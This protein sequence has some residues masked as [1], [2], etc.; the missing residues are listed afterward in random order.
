MDTVSARSWITL[1]VTK[2]L[3]ADSGQ[4][5]GALKKSAITKDFRPVVLNAKANIEIK[6][7]VRSF[8]SHNVIGKLEGSDPKLN[9]EYVIY[10]AHWDHLGRHPELQGDQISTVQSITHRVW[11]Q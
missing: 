7:Q 2:K 11:H 5:F 3:F 9:G 8:K 6:Q 1:D 10:T 4:D